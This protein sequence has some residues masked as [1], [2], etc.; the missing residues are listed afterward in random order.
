MRVAR[1]V[2]VLL[3][4]AVLGAVAT[5]GWAATQGN[6]GNV[7][8]MS[9]L[10]GSMAPALDVGDLVVTRMV[11][12]GDLHAGDVITYRAPTRDRFVTHRVQSIVWRGELADVLTR[13]DANEVGEEWTV[14]REG[15][16]GLVVLRLP[17][18][19]YALGVLDTAA[20]RLAVGIVAVVLALWSIELIWRPEPRRPARPVHARAAAHESRGGRARERP[21]TL[22]AVGRGR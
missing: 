15:T 2:A 18:A 13:G 12:P 11:R 7:R 1:S 21:P 5:L 19:G 22:Q 14:S 3:T 17:A 4:W 10:S 16:V 20:G 9:V 6:V 8:A